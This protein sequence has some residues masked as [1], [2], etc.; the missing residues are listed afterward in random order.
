M[1][2]FSIILSH[3]ERIMW[4]FVYDG[5]HNHFWKKIVSYL[6]LGV[7]N[8][9]QNHL[10]AGCTF[11][12]VAKKAKCQNMWIFSNQIKMN[13]LTW[14]LGGKIQCWAVLTFLWE[15]SV[16]GFG[17]GS[18][19]RPGFQEF[20]KPSKAF[21]RVSSSHRILKPSVFRDFSH[22]SWFIYKILIDFFWVFLFLQSAYF[23]WHE[24]QFSRNLVLNGVCPVLSTNH[25]CCYAYCCYKSSRAWC[26]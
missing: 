8:W 20:L 1:W 16:L 23:L 14:F 6:V 22:K 10:G 11:E 26:I 13:H 5:C 12:K 2:M 21:F 3:F 19:N 18:K 25:C 24:T 4:I 15:L 9:W 7:M 17:A